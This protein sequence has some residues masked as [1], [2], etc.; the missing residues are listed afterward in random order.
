MESFDLTVLGG[1]PGGYVAAIRGAQLGLKTALID[2]DR[3]GGV[4]LNW[5]CIPTKA[6]LKNA[7]VLNYVK[8]AGQYGIQIPEFQVDFPQTIRRSRQA[9]QRLSKGVAYLLKKN[10]VTHLVGR[11]RLRSAGEVG[12]QTR[13]GQETTLRSA[14]V[15]LATGGRPRDLPG[16]KRDGV[17]VI[18]SKEAL[19]LKAVP[20]RLIVV[21]AGAVGVELAYFYHTFGSVVQ[22]VEML[23]RIL[24]QEDEDVSRELEKQF[25]RAG[26]QVHTATRVTGLE[27]LKTVLKLSAERNGEAILLKGDLVLVAVGVTGNVEDIGLDSAGVRT[28]KGVIPVDEYCRTNLENVYAVGDVTGP[29]WLAHVASAQGQ[30]A[31]EHAAGEKPQPL[32]YTNIPACTYCQP[33]VASLGLT[34]ARAREQYGAVR[35]G[36]FD[37]KANGKALADGESGGFIKIIFDPRYGELLGC[38]ILGAGATEMIAEVGVAKTLE[39]TYH[40]IAATVHAH[41]TLAEALL[42]ATLDAYGTAI[43]K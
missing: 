15:I 16:V 23:P 4:C 37:F 11:G 41:P 29:P 14:K 42:E 18:A 35:V 27:K 10:R 6:L 19:V 43:H 3:L 32:D 5:G 1:G 13:E 22:L 26:L 34:E 12:V 2:Q 36:R 25:Q 7:Q 8:N 38:H 30:V 17:R 9:A 39:T 24:P 21:G 28:N 40:E 20:K 31:A 33:Q